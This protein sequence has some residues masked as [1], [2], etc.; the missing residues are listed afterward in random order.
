VKRLLVSSLLLCLIA[1]GFLGA[2]VPAIAPAE[3][4]REDLPAEEREE[5]ALRNSTSRRAQPRAK[6][7]RLPSLDLS[8]FTR[9]ALAM[10]GLVS[11]S[12]S[13][14]K[15]SFYPGHLRLLQVRRI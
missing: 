9:S 1:L 13:L 11:V 3:A 5:Q 2:Q 15:S 4:A 12:R 6:E 14:I 10:A 8:E 7:S